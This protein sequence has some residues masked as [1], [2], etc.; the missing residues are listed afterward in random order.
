MRRIGIIG[1]VMLSLALQAQDYARLSERTILGTARYVGMSG[2]MTAIGGDPSA[3]QDNPAGLGLYRRSEVMLTGDL[4]IDKTTSTKSL[5]H[6]S[7]AQA[8]VV[9]S[10]RTGNEDKGIIAHNLMFSYQRRRTYARTMYG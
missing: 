4:G 2:A 7:L 5:L 3:A 8:S 9:L 6:F 10:L 1:F